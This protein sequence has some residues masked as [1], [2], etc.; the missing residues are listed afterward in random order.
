VWYIDLS[1]DKNIISFEFRARGSPVT[2]A[3]FNLEKYMIYIIPYI[4]KYLI[5]SIRLMLNI[6]ISN[7]QQ[8]KIDPSGESIKI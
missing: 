5:H 7:P 2:Q 1:L 6:L 3:Q 4:L 8:L